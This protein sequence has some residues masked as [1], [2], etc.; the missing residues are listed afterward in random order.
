LGVA[1]GQVA[2]GFVLNVGGFA[3]E[4]VVGVLH[5]VVARIVLVAQVAVGIVF[6]AR[7]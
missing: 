3:V 2:R 1:D 7:G 4:V 5:K 6:K